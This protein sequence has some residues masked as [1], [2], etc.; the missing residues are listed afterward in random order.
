MATY[1]KHV[2]SGST[3]GRPIAITNTAATGTLIHTSVTASGDNTWDEI[4]IWAT[5][6]STSTEPSRLTVEFGGTSGADQLTYDTYAG[7]NVLVVP[8]LILHSGLVVRAFATAST[9]FNVAGY[10]NRVAT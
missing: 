1:T 5:N 4:Y 7:E 8:G 3:N 6:L 9:T 10:V 2:L